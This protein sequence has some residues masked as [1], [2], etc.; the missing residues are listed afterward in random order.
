MLYRWTVVRAHPHYH[1][2]LFLSIGNQFTLIQTFL[3]TRTPTCTHKYTHT[4]KQ[5]Y[6][7]QVAGRQQRL[8][9]KK[10]ESSR[11]NAITSS[12]SSSTSPYIN[13]DEIFEDEIGG[14]AGAVS[15]SREEND[16]RSTSKNPAT[17]LIDLVDRI[18]DGRELVAVW[19]SFQKKEIKGK[20]TNFLTLSCLISLIFLC[21]T[22]SCL[23]C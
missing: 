14:N 6:T 19:Q 8:L 3:H 11:K 5:V 2:K 9:L 21:L 4:H 7:G 1:S 10:E 18:S 15:G 23:S 20:N 22:L 13:D 12:T 17:S 16:G